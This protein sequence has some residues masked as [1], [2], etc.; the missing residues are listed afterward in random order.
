M[1]QSTRAIGTHVRIHEDLY[2]VIEVAEKFSL[3]AI[4]SFL[5]TE[6][7]EYVAVS[8]QMIDDFVKAKK[9]LGFLYYVHAAYWSGL[10]DSKSKMFHSLKKEVEFAQDLHAEGIV[11]HPGATKGRLSDKD[12]V[13]YVADSVNLMHQEHQGV[14]LLLENGPHAGRTFGGNLEHFAMLIEHVEKKDLLGFCIDTAHAFVYGYDIAKEQ[15]CEDFLRMLEDIIG[16]Q[17]IKLLH[18]NDSKDRCGSYIDKHEEPGYGLI[19]KKALQ[20]FMNHKLFK[21]VPLIME[22]SKESRH[23][24]EEVVQI[25]SEWN[26]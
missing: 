21:D 7:N 19:G 13:R 9:E 25:V 14:Q 18:F 23:P 15:H 12:K 2:D 11:I 16:K 10:T 3:L 8:N 4:Q 24:I 20:Q 1:K 5:I 26:Q 6:S 22:C 17:Y